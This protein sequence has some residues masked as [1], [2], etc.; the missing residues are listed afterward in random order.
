M[1]RNPINANNVIKA[2]A[3]KKYSSITSGETYYRQQYQCRH[4]NKSFANYPEL[5]FLMI[6]KINITYMIRLLQKRELLNHIS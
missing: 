6:F 3:V 1:E 2:Y 5:Q 4:C